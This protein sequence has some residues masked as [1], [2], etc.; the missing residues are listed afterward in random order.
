LIETGSI[1]P[2]SVAKENMSEILT[3]TEIPMEDRIRKL[4]EDMIPYFGVCTNETKVISDPKK[5]YG[6][7]Q[8]TI[9]VENPIQNLTVFNNIWLKHDDM[10]NLSIKFS[11]TSPFNYCFRV[12]PKNNDSVTN[13]ANDEDNCKEW[14]ETDSK[15][16]VYTHF[17]LKTFNVYNVTLYLKN[18]VSQ[19]RTNIGVHFYEGKL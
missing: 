13:I 6:Y 2:E 3:T 7:Y 15:N 14:K 17:F 1:R 8:R 12:I 19:V 16:I 11:G 4:K 9:T 5:I 18:Q 10:C